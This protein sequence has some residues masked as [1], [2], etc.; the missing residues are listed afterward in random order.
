MIELK[1]EHY[2]DGDHEKVRVF[3]G[4]ED[5]DLTLCGELTMRPEEWRG[6]AGQLRYGNMQTYAEMVI[7]PDDAH[8]VLDSIEADLDRLDRAGG[9]PS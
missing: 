8:A 3:A 4:P 2:R 5:G 7:S 6:L 1:F 9:G